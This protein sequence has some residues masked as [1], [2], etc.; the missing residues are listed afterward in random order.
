MLEVNNISKSYAGFQA[1]KDVSLAVRPGEI[2]G[3]VGPNGAGKS[4]TLRMI[5]GVEE[6]DSGNATINGQRVRDLDAPLAT[7]GALIDRQGVLKELTPVTAIR[8]LAAAYGIP[9]SRGWELLEQVGLGHALNRRVGAFSLGM[10]QRLGIALALLGEPQ[11][12]ILDEPM[13]GLDPDGI[14]WLRELLRDFAQKGG[15][16]LLSS[17]SL[18]EVEEVADTIAMVNHG[19]TIW[20]G[21]LGDIHATSSRVRVSTTDNPRLLRELHSHGFQADMG[22]GV[23]EVFDC[24]NLQVGQ[25]LQRGGFVPLLL[26]IHHTSLE[27]A[28]LQF[29]TPEHRKAS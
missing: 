5:I 11:F 10:K 12:L 26:T 8:S 27:D 22:D 21:S 9:T 19:T 6:P 2:V 3:F 18:A 23:I 29:T 1:V 14:I 20:S 16:V 28:Y 4:T 15:G 17:H 7:F 24:E 25:L 13:N